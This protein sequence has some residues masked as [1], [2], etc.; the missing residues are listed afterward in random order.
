MKTPHRQRTEESK[1]NFSLPNKCSKRGNEEKK[2]VNKVNDEKEQRTLRL[3]LLLGAE[4]AAELPL[5]AGDNSDSIVICEWRRF[6]EQS[7]S[8]FSSSSI[9]LSCNVF[10]HRLAS[11]LFLLPRGVRGSTLVLVSIGK[12]IPLI[13]WVE[14][15]F[16]TWKIHFLPT[17]PQWVGG[18]FRTQP[19]FIICVGSS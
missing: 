1:V 12:K 6:F 10:V 14:L 7:W 4:V 3:W 2:S 5:E 13:F 16:P 8:R 19:V 11:F 15:D 17:H 9:I 18:C